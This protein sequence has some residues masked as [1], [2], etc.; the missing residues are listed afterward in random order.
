MSSTVIS[1]LQT[2]SCLS[3]PGSME[4]V[5]LTD[6]NHKHGPVKHLSTLSK[7]TKGWTHQPQGL[8]R[9]LSSTLTT[10][11]NKDRKLKKILSTLK[12]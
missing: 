1:E 5:P 2:L 3:L 9:T 10:S 7:V 4:E 11:S 8:D 12:Y 6:E